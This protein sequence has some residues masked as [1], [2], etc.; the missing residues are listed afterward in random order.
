MVVVMPDALS[1]LTLAVALIAAGLLAGLIAGLLGVGGGIVI[2][3]VLFHL[4]NLMGYDPAV[5]MHLAVGTSLASIVPTSISAVRSHL[6]R[7]AV[8]VPLLWRWAPGVVAGV[9]IGT[10]L[11]GAVQGAVLTGLFATVALLVA[12]YMTLVGDG[13]RLRDGLPGRAVQ[14][15]I[16]ALIGAFSSMMG[17]GGGTLTVPSLVLCNYPIRRAVATS[18]AIGMIIAIPGALGFMITGADIA[19][20][21]P[22]SLGYVSLLGLMLT[23]PTAM[24]TAPF[25]A[26]L[27]H[28]LN[29][30]WLRRAFALFLLLTSAH[31]FL[32]LLR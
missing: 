11:A 29:P 19:G 27:A 10:L 9:V 13:V 22:L 6:L 24:L 14:S 25:G 16:A 4:F 32:S 7:D 30:R 26:R 21:P 8:D 20:R 18:S 12:L 2:V 31:M 17:I 3:P 5:T 1:L 15:L 28:T 23:A